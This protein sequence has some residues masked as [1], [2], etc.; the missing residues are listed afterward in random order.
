MPQKM[1]L[2]IFLSLCLFSCKKYEDGVYLSFQSRAARINNTWSVDQ[3]SNASGC[4]IEQEYTDYQFT[5]TRQGEASITFPIFPSGEETLTGTWELTDDN[6]R[7]RWIVTGDT[8]AF[9]Y[10]GYQTFDILRLTGSEFWL[11]DDANAELRLAP[12]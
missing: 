10:N 5:F 12:Q 9:L 7:F 2:W 1:L 11:V 8:L 4:R 3:A 6:D